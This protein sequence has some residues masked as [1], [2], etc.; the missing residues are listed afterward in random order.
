MIQYPKK[1][2]EFEIHSSI[3]NKLKALGYDVRGEVTFINKNGGRNARFDL[4]I[5][6][7]KNAI[8]IIEVK[9]SFRRKPVKVD[10]YSKM[11]GVACIAIS[12][13]N[14]TERIELIKKL[15]PV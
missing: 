10:R 5:F 13:V 11:T 3:F 15:I 7:N 12:A 8:L 1:T 6:K 2:S 4:V 14:M 9:R